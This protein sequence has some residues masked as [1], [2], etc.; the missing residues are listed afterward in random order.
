VDAI[1]LTIAL[2]AYLV[3]VILSKRATARSVAATAEFLGARKERRAEWIDSLKAHAH[4]A[5]GEVPPMLTVA[6]EGADAVVTNRSGRVIIV[7]LARVLPDPTAPGGW[8]ACPMHTSAH[9]AFRTSVG[10]RQ[11][12]RFQLAANCAQTFTGAPI[13]YRVGNNPPD[14]GWWSDSAIA[15]PDW[16]SPGGPDRAMPVYVQPKAPPQR[17]PGVEPD[18][19]SYGDTIS[20]GA[21][22]SRPAAPGSNRR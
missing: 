1:V 19:R 11:P 20:A 16:P 2:G 21:P 3:P 10:T 8:R 4:G 18:A 13:E 6:D 7:A 22:E 15:T 9:S 12:E 17:N 5:P 14:E